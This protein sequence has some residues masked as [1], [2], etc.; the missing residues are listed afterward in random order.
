[1]MRTIGYLAQTYLIQPLIPQR[2]SREDINAAVS[3]VAWPWMVSG[4]HVGEH[5]VNTVDPAP[6][7]TAAPSGSVSLLDVVSQGRLVACYSHKVPEA[8]YALLVGVRQYRLIELII[9]IQKL[10]HQNYH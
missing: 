8:F 3:R 4:S 9:T 1:M 7:K 5:V 2:V 6:F 10:W